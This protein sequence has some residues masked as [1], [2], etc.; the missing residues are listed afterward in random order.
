MM[1]RYKGKLVLV[2]GILIVAAVSYYMVYYASDNRTDS[3]YR[4][5]YIPKIKDESNDF[6]TSLIEGAQMAAEEYQIDLKIVAADT[7]DDYERQNQ[8]ILEAIKEKP[9]AIL[10]S[11][12]HYSEVADAAKQVK[13]AGIKL[14]LVDSDLDAT[15]QDALIATDNYAAGEKMGKFAVTSLID[16]DTV[17]GIVSHV[18]GASTAIQRRDGLLKG[19]GIDAKRVVDTVYCNSDYELAYQVTTELMN[20]QP[21]INLI[22]GLNEYSAV[23]AA[24][25][26]KDMELTEQV[27]L[28]GVDSSVEEIR[29]LEEGVFSAI[30][31]QKPFVMGYLGVET[32]VQLLQGETT[33][34]TVDSDSEVITKENMYTEE[35]QKLLFPFWDR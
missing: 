33:S 13:A 1:K 25:A 18:K 11:P 14:V 6:W 27:K 16:E 32:A 31:I 3:R 24:R 23:G 28:V 17:I 30:V 5:V 9:E 20:K 26:I 8:L 2:I 10:L 21:Q 4:M 7:E 15:I 19:L 22:F 34:A 29:L 12:S 35:N